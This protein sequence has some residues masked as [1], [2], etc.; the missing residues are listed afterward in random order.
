VTLHVRSLPD[1]VVEVLRERIVAGHLAA[2]TAIRQDTIAR[3]LGVSKIPVREALSRLAQ[4]G[5][6]VSL[7]RRGWYVRPLT[8][9]EAEDLYALRQSLEPASASRAAIAADEL[10]QRA[11]RDAYARLLSDGQLDPATAARRNR[12]FHLALIAP[13][14]RPL[15]R[16]LVERLTLL[17]ERYVVQHLR[18]NGRSSRAAGEHSELAQAWL[19][20]DGA[21]VTAAL[22]THIEGTLRDLQSELGA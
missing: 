22:S 4:D 13:D 1:Q 16:Q 7:P 21:T 9:A 20:R 10:Q 14:P 8:L 2:D 15:T 19:D 6:V 18:P 5:L 12:D 17:A 11:L 3:E